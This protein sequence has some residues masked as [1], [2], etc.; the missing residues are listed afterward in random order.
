[1]LRRSRIVSH[2]GTIDDDDC[3]GISTYTGYLIHPVDSFGQMD[4]SPVAQKSSSK[5]PMLKDTRHMLPVRTMVQKVWNSH[6]PDIIQAMQAL[7]HIHLIR[8]SFGMPLLGRKRYDVT[9]L[10][11]TIETLLSSPMGVSLVV[12][13]DICNVP[14]SNPKVFAALLI[15]E[16]SDSDVSITT[17]LNI[18]FSGATS[19]LIT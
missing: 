11:T 8:R 16:I 19:L 6:I 1:M 18:L 2:T 17:D 9:V 14:S 13:N 3:I 12:P 7:I 10:P 15:Q 4:V 5:Q